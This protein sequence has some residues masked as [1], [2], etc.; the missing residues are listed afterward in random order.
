[1]SRANGS[2]LLVGSV[3]GQSAAEVMRNCAGGLGELLFGLPDGETGLRWAWINFL[4]AQTYDHCPDL[5]TVARPNPIDPGFA[6]EWRS[7]GMDWCPQGFQ[8]HWQFKVRDGVSK[9]RFDRLGYAEDAR[10][11]YETFRELR[12]EGV[13]PGGMRFQ[14]SLPLIESG[15]RM[16]L[17][18]S[19]ESFPI[20]WD[21][22]REAMV[23]E[24]AALCEYVPP[25]DLSV[26]WD[27]AVEVIAMEAGD[28]APEIGLPW[29]GP[30]EPLDRYVQALAALSPHVPGDALLGLHLCYGDIGH[31]HAIQ[32]RDL[33]VV[34]AM[35]NAGVANAGRSVDYAHIPV[36]RD[37]HDDAYFAPLEGLQIGDT[38]LFI[39]LVH[40]TDGLEGTLR[41]LET[42]RK[43]ASGFGI[44]TECGWGR[45]APETLPE[46]MRIHTETASRL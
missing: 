40:H 5:E 20:M 36:P 10:Q 39:G 21:A 11:S 32:P 41:R 38:R 28:H 17:A 15:T 2:V 25:R 16:F 33:G 26:Q 44:S 46:L 34:T 45:R 37:R 14:V 30:G 29:D 12:D 23:R 9:V 7:E 18:R 42:A 22:Y 43:Y 8:D 31:R 6:G 19:P 27:I 24:L 1:M 13:I 35:A 4:A 3:V